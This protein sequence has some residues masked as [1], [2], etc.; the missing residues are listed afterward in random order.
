MKES[1]STESAFGLKTKP[2]F[3]ANLPASVSPLLQQP[4]TNS[5]TALQQQ[6]AQ[7]QQALKR[8]VPKTKPFA[9]QNVGL[10]GTGLTSNVNSLAAGIGPSKAGSGLGA[11]A[12]EAKRAQESWKRQMEPIR[13]AQ[14]S[15]K[16]QME[17]LRRLAQRLAAY[18]N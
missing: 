4:N 1:T 6:I 7:S 5:I 9:G 17:P 3:L 15:R 14:E 16:R 8:F 10:L 18:E 11:L 13:R 2:A 12:S